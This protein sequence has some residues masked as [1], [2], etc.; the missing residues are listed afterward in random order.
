MLLRAFLNHQ[1]GW[2]SDPQNRRTSPRNRPPES[3][4]ANCHRL[5]CLLLNLLLLAVVSAGCGDNDGRLSVSGKVT[6]D[7]K[8]LPEGSIEFL[9]IAGTG[10]PT[11]G[12]TIEQGKYRIVPRRGLFAGR[13]RVNIT[14]NRKTGAQRM[15]RYRGVKY[16]VQ[17][18][19]LPTRYNEKSQ[20]EAEVTDEG[21]NVFA[22]ELTSG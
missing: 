13:F 21:P 14:A 20:L 6:L 10:G 22:F 12:A 3:L 1:S 16:D 4:C 19:Y 7:G 18:Q 17:E 9:P 8:P 15:D 2:Q 5:F 11:A